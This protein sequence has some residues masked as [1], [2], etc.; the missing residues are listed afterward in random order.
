MIFK[1]LPLKDAYMI[2]LELNDDERGFFSRLYCYDD[3]KK[4]GIDFKISQINN[5]SSLLRG[6]LRG[7]H[8]QSQPCSEQKLV[9]CINGRIWDVII[10]LR[11]KSKTF[12]N[13]FGADLTAE[14]RKMIFVPKGFGHGY[15]S[16]SDN[17]EIIYFVSE[18]YSPKHEIGFRWDDPTFKINWPIEPTV[19]SKKDREFLDFDKNNL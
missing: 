2:S 17:S 3:F 9:R 16:L 19:I 1:P 12:G 11:L 10:D 13:W 15:I 7:I 4:N 14:N 18:K 8:L 6:T 5:A